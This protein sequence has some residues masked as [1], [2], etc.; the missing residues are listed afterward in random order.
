MECLKVLLIPDL[1]DYILPVDEMGPELN[2]FIS[3]P[4]IFHFKDGDV[5][6]DEQELNKILNYIDKK[7]GLDFREYKY[8]TLARRVARRVNICKCKNLKEYYDYLNF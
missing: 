2:E 7:A 5:Q 8:A 1:V 4:P 3:A 6:Y